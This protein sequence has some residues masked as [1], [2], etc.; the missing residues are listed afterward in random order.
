MEPVFETKNGTVLYWTGETFYTED[1]DDVREAL[2]ENL[3]SDDFTK[4]IFAEGL[5]QLLYKHGCVWEI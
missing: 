2:K 1:E 3:Q 5:W 4:V